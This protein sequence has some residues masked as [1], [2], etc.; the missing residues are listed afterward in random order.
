M[1][2]L[3]LTGILQ[4]AQALPAAPQA[5]QASAYDCH[6]CSAAFDTAH[7]LHMHTAKMHRD[8]IQ[9]FIPPT[10][11]RELPA[12]DGMPVCAACNKSFKQWKGLRDH[13]LSGA[14]PAPGRFA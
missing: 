1:F 6:V 4:E 2:S 7:G 10:F 11:D 9:R 8:T 3:T 14:C 5:P 12:K 13:L